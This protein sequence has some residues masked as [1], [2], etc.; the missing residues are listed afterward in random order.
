MEDWR[1][2]V[3]VARKPDGSLKSVACRYCK[4]GRPNGVAANAT[5]CKKH[6]QDCHPIAASTPESE[7]LSAA[8]SSASSVP[9]TVA[10]FPVAAF[11]VPARS[12]S[13]PNKRP[14]TSQQSLEK[15]VDRGFDKW[16]QEAAESRLV[17]WQAKNAVSLSSL[18][19]E[20]FRS[21]CRALRVDFHLPSRRTLQRRA[22]DLFQT[23]QSKVALQL[24]S[25]GKCAMAVDGWK[26]HHHQE[27]LGA[28]A[29]PLGRKE[30]PLI[31][32][33]EEQTCRQVCFFCL[34]P[35]TLSSFHRHH[36][37]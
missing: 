27:T 17:K 36:T 30:K 11:P 14:R 9:G 8:V 15:Y 37:I 28:C 4:W 34:A 19:S 31:V 21:F 33:L 10:A 12:P 29:L 13:P 18:D 2:Y 6:T 23:L 16:Q 5:R 32:L 20:E 3:P 25:W 24:A 26:N 22:A 1:H 35:C 7:Q